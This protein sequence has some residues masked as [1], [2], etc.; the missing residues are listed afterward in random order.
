MTILI[1]SQI[2]S[3]YTQCVQMSPKFTVN[4]CAFKLFP[5]IDRIIKDAHISKTNSEISI[6]LILVQIVCI[7]QEC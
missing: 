4:K 3:N 5:K 6:N 7:D 2:E 1:F